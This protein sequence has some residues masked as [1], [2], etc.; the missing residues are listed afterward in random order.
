MK[1]WGQRNSAVP[2]RTAAASLSKTRDTAKYNFAHIIAFYCNLLLDFKALGGWVALGFQQRITGQTSP[3]RPPA[4]VATR[5]ARV[6]FA[7]P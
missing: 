5:L 3:V 2:R 6:G 4:L 7:Q 1:P